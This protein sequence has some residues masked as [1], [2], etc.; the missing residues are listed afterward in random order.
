[1]GT[2]LTYRQYVVAT[3]ASSVFLQ[4]SLQTAY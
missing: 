2:T 3:L 4:T 1:M